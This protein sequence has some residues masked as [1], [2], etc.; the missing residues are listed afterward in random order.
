MARDTERQNKILFVQAQLNPPGGGEAVAVWMLQALRHDY[1][2]TILTSVPIDIHGVNRYYGTS[3]RRTDFVIRVMPGILRYL[4]D[5][6]PSDSRHYMRVCGLMRWCKLIGHRFDIVM[7]AY[8][9]MD[10]GVRGLQYVHYPFLRNHWARE[11]DLDR[12]DRWHASWLRFYETRLRPWRLISGFSF[13]RMRKNLTIVNSKWTGDW[14]TE[15]YG[16]KVRVIYPPV[17]GKFPEIPWREKENGFVC[18][19][20]LSH[21]KRVVEMIRILSEVR[22]VEPE[23]HL[24]IIGSRAPYEHHYY[25]RIKKAIAQQKA[26]ISLHEDIS[27][28]ELLALVSRHRYGIHGMADEHFGIAVAEML[29]AGCIPFVPNS[30]GQAEIIGNEPRLMYGTETEA[31][32]KILRIVKSPLE[33]RA[34][35]QYLNRR[36]GLFTTDAFVH[37]IRS[38][39]S[40]TLN[41]MEDMEG[42]PYLSSKI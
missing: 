12:Q 2:V 25:E 4:L 19:G 15:T 26:W 31:V 1:D 8:N 37:R 38:V 36:K 28:D 5:C 23:I 32:E 30:G 39:I 7:S 10:Y 21:V 22:R 42:D 34:L 20:R 35:R 9:E 11:V 24:H 18:M 6:L 27:R 14:F 13:Q 41:H 33:Q 29:R 3:L 16:E 40:D 17:H